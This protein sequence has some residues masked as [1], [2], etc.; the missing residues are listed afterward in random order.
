MTLRAGSAE[1]IGWA[2]V[3]R[4]CSRSGSATAILR[5]YA[6]DCR[7]WARAMDFAAAALAL[8]RRA[9]RAV[10]RRPSSVLDGH[11]GVTSAPRLLIWAAAIIALRHVITA[12]LPIHRHLSAV[13]SAWSRSAALRTALL[14]AR[15]DQTAHVRGRLPRGGD[16]RLRT[17]RRAVP[18]FLQRTAEPAAAMGCGLVLGI[19]TRGYECTSRRRRGRAAEHR[20][21]PG[22]SAAGPICRAV[23]PA[24]ARSPMCSARRCCRW[25][26]SRSRSSTCICS[27]ARQMD[28]DQATAA[29]GCWRRFRSR[30]FSARSTPSR[31]IC[32]APSARSII[33]DAREF[34]WAA[35]WGILVR[36]D[37]AERFFICGPLAI[38]VL[39]ER[40]RR[41][42]RVARR[43]APA[44][45]V[46]LLFP[47]RLA[48]AGN[49]IAWGSAMRRG[50]DTMAG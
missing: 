38:L 3:G 24:K 45:G 9:H 17:R 14:V 29:S 35:V 36:A 8:R 32:L 33:S 47:V 2:D 22:I 37:E 49:P 12:D 41:S 20:V 50:D 16:V 5:R 39:A 40:S 44:A 11:L 10:R 46:A 15:R 6:D 34:G 25:R 27:R 21:L 42:P 1:R 13:V 43:S 18:R 30:C 48:L 28:E 7:V 4:G 23:R 31:C 19:A 26:C